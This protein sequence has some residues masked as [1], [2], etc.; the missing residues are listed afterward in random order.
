MFCH[1][2]LYF[3]YRKKV[4]PQNNLNQLEL[5]K[6]KLA[7]HISYFMYIKIRKENM[8]VKVH[9]QKIIL[10]TKIRLKSSTCPLSGFTTKSV[11]IYFVGLISSIS[12]LQDRQKLFQIY[13]LL[14]HVKIEKYVYL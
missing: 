3:R 7:I 9:K 4:I 11:K 1:G 8:L 12:N 6:Y 14:M 2:M 5:L 10:R 13:R